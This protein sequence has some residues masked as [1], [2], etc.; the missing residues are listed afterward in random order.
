MRTRFSLLFFLTM[1][2]HTASCEPNRSWF[3]FYGGYAFQNEQY[4]QSGADRNSHGVDFGFSLRL[5]PF[6]G[7]AGIYI[8]LYCAM[9]VP[10]DNAGFEK[11]LAEQ[12]RAAI[13]IREDFNPIAHISSTIGAS[14]LFLKKQKL[15]IGADAGLSYGFGINHA[16]AWEEYER[17]DVSF[18]PEL[19]LMR[20]GVAGGFFTA[21]GQSDF[22]FEMGL[23][24]GIYPLSVYESAEHLEVGSFKKEMKWFPKNMLFCIGVYAG[25]SF[26]V[27]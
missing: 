16:M 7:R 26:F 25:V 19:K 17:G 11:Y 20:F 4:L 24:A 1:I 15:S 14:F 10:I 3:T 27:S 21:I 18:Y 13:S 12:Y 22:N 5:F 6:A 2:S 8:D 23:K 9:P